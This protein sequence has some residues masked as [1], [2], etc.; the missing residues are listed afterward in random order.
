MS[1]SSARFTLCLAGTLAFSVVCSASADVLLTIPAGTFIVRDG[2]P[3][4]MPETNYH[5]RI[6]TDGTDGMEG[7]NAE[8]QP[9]HPEDLNH[10]GQRRRVCSGQRQA[11][12]HQRP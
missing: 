6:T 9:E 12:D 5:F 10:Q 1:S 4:T 7:V 8:G 11:G 3:W 2:L